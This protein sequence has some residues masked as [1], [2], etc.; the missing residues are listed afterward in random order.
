M[1]T[2]RAE[3]AEPVYD[4]S[5][6]EAPLRPGDKI[7]HPLFGAGTIVE[8]SGRGEGQKVVV[9]FGLAGRRKLVVATASLVR[10]G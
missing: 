8:S 10:I 1:I 6:G 7:R 2:R 9:Q 3:R 4:D 5:G